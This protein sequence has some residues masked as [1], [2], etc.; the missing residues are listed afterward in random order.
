MND[1]PALGGIQTVDDIDT[2]GDFERKHT[3]FLSCE[4][5]DAGVAVHIEVGHWVVHPNTADH[6]IGWLEL[7]VDGVAIA[8]IDLQGGV[9]DPVVDL[10]VRVEPGTPLTAVASCNLHGVWGNSAVAP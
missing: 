8:R 9:T 3:P 2:A 10:L 1:S 4:R 5:T 6:F 7:L